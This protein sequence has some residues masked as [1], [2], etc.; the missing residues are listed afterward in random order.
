[1]ESDT[2]REEKAM[3]ALES[4][5]MADYA[6]D[7]SPDRI[8]DALR[9]ARNKFAGLPIRDFVPVLVERTARR[10]LAVVTEKETAEEE[11]EPNEAPE[12]NE[13]PD[14]VGIVDVVEPKPGP[15]NRS[16]AWWHGLVGRRYLLPAFGGVGA[17]VLVLA[18]GVAVTRPEPAPTPVAS[19]PLT[20]VRG[21]V[22]SEKMAFFSDPRVIDAFAGHGIEVAVEPAGSREIATGVDLGDYDFAFPSSL[23]AADRVKHEVEVHNHYTP[24]YSPM[25]IATFDP[26]VDVLTG[27]G[28]V[29]PGPVPTLDV[30]AYLDMV[31]RGVQWDQLEGNTAYPVRKNVLVST[32]DPRSSNS[33]AMYLAVAGYVANDHAV[34]RGA[35]AEQHVLPLLSRLTL[36]QGYTEGSTAGPFAG[37][38]DAGMGPTPMAWIYESQ[39]MSATVEGKIAPDMALLYPSPTVVS[40]H[41]LVPLGDHGDTVGRLLATD[42]ELQSLAVEHGY[43][44]GDAEKFEQVVAEHDVPVTDELLDVVDV[45]AYETLERL[46]VGVENAYR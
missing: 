46:L 29:R 39:Y 8:A 1:M 33:A 23:P 35:A 12:E 9:N 14:T 42:P 20:K 18:V 10:D 21:V 37:Y 24:F 5:L 31:A 16:R 43:R 2:A 44:T 3:R 6:Q 7:H 32:S 41:T 28:V 25:A 15:R 19:T 17:L 38:L 27:A 11:P 13:T 45:P 36:G 26:I 34:V 4:R 30:S 40:R 22:G